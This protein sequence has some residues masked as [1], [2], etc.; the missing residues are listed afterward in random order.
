MATRLMAFGPVARSMAQGIISAYEDAE[1]EIPPI[2]GGE[3]AEW[4]PALGAGTRLPISMA[5]MY[6][7]AMITRLP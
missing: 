2:A 6:P 1:M 4:L 5:W 3:T 7:N